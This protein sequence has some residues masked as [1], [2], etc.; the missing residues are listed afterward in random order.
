MLHA[1][2]HTVDDDGTAD[3]TTIQSAVDAAVDGDEIQVLPGVYRGNGSE[4]VNLL[5]KRV[6]V[7][8]LQ[9]PAVTT[10]D[11]EGLRRCLVATG[12]E[13]IA[14][15]LEGFTISNGQGLWVDLDGDGSPVSSR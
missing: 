13:T 11:G 1:D 10:I 14:T 5:G 8:S 9:G 4:V 3:F 7:R 12:G 6:R 15:S 2:I